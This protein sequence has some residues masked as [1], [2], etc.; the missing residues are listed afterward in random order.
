MS[1]IVVAKSFQQ[2]QTDLSLQ[3]QADKIHA[4]SVGL[5]RNLQALGQCPQ[6]VFH[7]SGRSGHQP[8]DPLCTRRGS[9]KW[10]PLF[11]QIKEQHR[12]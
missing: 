6:R 8:S 2:G 1:S 5:R 7:L 12:V 10:F 9:I 11:K 3:S 4:T